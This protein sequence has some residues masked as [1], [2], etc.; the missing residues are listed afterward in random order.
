MPPFRLVY[1]EG[2]DLHLG[3]HVFPSQKYRWIH[4]R[5]LLDRFVG[6]EDFVT[7]EPAADEDLLLVHEPG[8]IARLKSGTLTYQ[9]IV[10]L[11]IAYSRQ[12][13]EAYWLATGG[14]IL[15]ARMALDH[16]LGF[17]LGGGFH[18]AFP[19]HGEGFCAI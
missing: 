18:H 7:P 13:V 15:A 14:T 2:Y 10:R 3:E 11:E 5:L 1:H 16:G 8:W 12:T 19:G 4:D 6:P 17:N 9:E